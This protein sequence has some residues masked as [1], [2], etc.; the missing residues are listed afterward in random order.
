MTRRARA[1]FSALLLLVAGCGRVH[2]AGS[3]QAAGGAGGASTSVGGGATTATA[4]AS[5]LAG[6]SA[7]SAAVQDITSVVPA[8]ISRLD[9]FELNRSIA[10]L[11]P[12]VEGLRPLPS[13]DED[14]VDDDPGSTQT[15]ALTAA[16]HEIA[17]ELGQRISA[18]AAVLRAT[19]GC[20]PET[21]GEADCR[22]QFLRQFL[23]SAFRRP[24]TDDD[25]SE[26]SDVFATGVSLGGD[27][28][29]GVRAV[30][31]VT[32]QS[33]EF[34]YL[35]ELGDG[36]IRHDVV[37]SSGAEGNGALGDAVELTGYESAARLS[38]F[39]TGGPPDAELAALADRGPLGTDDLQ[40]QAERLLQTSSSRPQVRH[41]FARLL[42]LKSVQPLPDQGYSAE[43]AAAAREETARFVE[44]VTFD[45]EGTFGA[46][47]T[48]RRTWVN[49]PL[50]Q[51]Y[52]YP[53][54][55]GDGFVKIALEPNQ[56]GGILTQSAFLREASLGY[57][58]SPSH[59]GVSVLTQLLCVS[60]PQPPPGVVQPPP[61]EQPGLTYRQRLEQD[62]SEA[63]C[64]SCHHFI[65]PIGYAFG[66]YD[67]LGRYQELENGLPIDASGTASLSSGDESFSGAIELSS[68]IAESQEGKACFV[69]RWVEM[70]MR[71][72][73]SDQDTLLITPLEQTFETSG[74]RTLD[75]MAAISQIGNFRYRLKAEVG[76]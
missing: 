16:L 56:R 15:L 49:G 31:E 5:G 11:L 53:N 21:A 32:L 39:V 46:L 18:D 24:V 8:P 3:E 67:E 74:Q 75:L 29:S 64:A 23:R 38:Y 71:R 65:D 19:T 9:H 45:A 61:P 70:A 54:I 40:A 52:G 73:A 25:L 44:D 27:F 34:A 42:D 59:R 13:L 36:Q 2:Q 63:L 48:A 50:A 12:E 41:F 43:V 66:H 10:A 69:R 47:F 37:V 7:G 55:T 30:V 76:P 33:P 22:E 72:A 26:M 62:T 4:G 28:A 68:I 58:A 51:F 35:I 57:H 14:A 17:H 20:D 60:V 6:S 1:T